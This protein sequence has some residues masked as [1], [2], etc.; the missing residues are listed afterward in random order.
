[1]FYRLHLSFKL[2][3]HRKS[4]QKPKTSPH[5]PT[6]LHGTHVL[7]HHISVTAAS[8]VLITE[9]INLRHL[10]WFHAIT[11]QGVQGNGIL[12]LMENCRGVQWSAL[13]TAEL[14]L[15]PKSEI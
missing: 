10:E 4:S 8:A 9:I 7:H 13:H 6:A 12:V 14:G 15:L 1:M 2:R 3:Y 11:S 5:D